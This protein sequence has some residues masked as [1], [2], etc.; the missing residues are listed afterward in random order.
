MGSCHQL[1]FVVA[2]AASLSWIVIAVKNDLIIGERV[3]GDEQIKWKRIEVDASWTGLPVTASENFT[4]INKT[5]TQIRA[6]DQH[7]NGYGATAKL[8]SGGVNQ[9]YCVLEFKSRYFRAIDFV[10]EIY[11]LNVTRTL[12]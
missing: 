3:Q 6:L 10:V 5:I 8:T 4:F 1:L 11:G 9:T 2:F 12:Y 7:E